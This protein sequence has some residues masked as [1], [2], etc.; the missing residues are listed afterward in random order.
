MGQ[1]YKK[2]GLILFMTIF[3]SKAIINK[4]VSEVYTFLSDMNNH[5]KLMPDTISG[6]SSST[7]E[8]QF[9]IQNMGNLSL[10]IAD[11]N[12]NNSIMII[13]AQQAPFNIELK[14]VLIETDINMTEALLTVSAEL[15]M[16]MKMLVS[17][18]LQKLVNYQ[19]EKLVSV[20]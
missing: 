12:I 4:S 3:E 17:G 1:F 9:I 16:M 19:T 7:D 11:K 14:W 15:N 5:Q 20:I 6:W 13:P 8:A 18:P 2:S 10:K